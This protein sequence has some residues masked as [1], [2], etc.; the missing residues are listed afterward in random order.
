MI[1]T[2]NV[3][4]FR[5][6][7]MNLMSDP[8]QVN[9]ISCAAVNRNICYD[10]EVANVVMRVRAERILRLAALEST[11]HLVLG[12]WGCG[13]FKNRIDFVVGVFMKLLLSEKFKGVF[14]TVTFPTPNDDHFRTMSIALSKRLK[15]NK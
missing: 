8:F 6:M 10:S 9:V 4:V 13:V 3:T 15:N 7:E 2:S 14:K 12:A 1:F 11:D 5:D